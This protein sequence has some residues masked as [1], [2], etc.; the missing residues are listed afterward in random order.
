MIRVL[1]NDGRQGSR[2]LRGGVGGADALVSVSG[3]GNLVTIS[4]RR[5]HLHGGQ[6]QN[7]RAAPKLERTG[8]RHQER[9]P[10]SATGSEGRRGALFWGEAEQCPTG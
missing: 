7:P 10:K 6:K 2:G 5:F 4:E 9:L 1:G 8:V 3:G